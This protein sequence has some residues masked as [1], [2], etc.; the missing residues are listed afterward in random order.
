MSVRT[1]G[2]AGLGLLGRGIAACLLGHG[3]RVIAFTR[4]ES[5][6]AEARKYIGRAIDDLIERAGFPASLAQQWPERF[7][8]GR[9]CQPLAQGEFL[10]P[11]LL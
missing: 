3:F 1:I 9:S 6:H 8:P 4:Q 5:T 2:L 10:I 7:V 11:N